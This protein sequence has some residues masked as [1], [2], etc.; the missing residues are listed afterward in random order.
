MNVPS[1]CWP[2][3]A[4]LMNMSSKCRDHGAALMIVSSKCTALVSS[5]LC[6]EQ[7]RC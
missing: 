5:N 6:M 1:E 3:G 4:A 2:Q 7:S